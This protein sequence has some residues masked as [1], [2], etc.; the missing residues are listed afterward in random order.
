MG[1]AAVTLRY[2]IG[3]MLMP[4]FTKLAAASAAE[5]LQYYDVQPFASNLP[6]QAL[7][8]FSGT[9]HQYSATASI[10]KNRLGIALTSTIL[11]SILI[12]FD[13]DQ[14]A[15][16][17]LN[18]GG[19]YQKSFTVGSAG[20][21]PIYYQVTTYAYNDANNLNIVTTVSNPSAVNAVTPPTINVTGKVFLYLAPF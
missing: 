11:S 15:G 2:I 6:S 1:L 18:L 9:L 17:F 3:C 12:N 13:N 21:F 16:K 5:G 10:P 7:P 14:S 4:D 19:Q 8:L 20:G